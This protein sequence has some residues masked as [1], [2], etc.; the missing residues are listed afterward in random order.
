LECERGL[1]VLVAEEPP[2]VGV[3]LLQRFEPEEQWQVARAEVFEE[4]AEVAP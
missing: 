2:G 1:Q 3:V 4:A